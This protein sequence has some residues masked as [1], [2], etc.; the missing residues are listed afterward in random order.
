MVVFRYWT[1]KISDD[2]AR[3]LSEVMSTL[4]NSFI[5]RPQQTLGDLRLTSGSQRQSASLAMSEPALKDMVS[6]C[7]RE[8]VQQL[9]SNGALFGSTA[10][11]AASIVGS[12]IGP[13]LQ[14]GRP[15]PPNWNYISDSTAVEYPSD[16]LDTPTTCTDD[17]S[18]PMQTKN[19]MLGLVRPSSCT[20][21]LRK[22]WST[23]LDKELDQIKDNAGFFDLGGDSIT[24]MRLAGAAR[25][26]GLVMKVA[27][28]FK[29]P[30]FA[31]MAAKV[32]MAD[33][34]DSV[35]KNQIKRNSLVNISTA[36]ALLSSDPY[37]RYSL[38]KLRNVEAFLQERI[39]PKIGVFR[40]GIA[41]VF[42]VTNFQAL[43]VTGVLL[44]CKW[45]LNYF[46]LDGSGCV[47][48]QRLKQAAFRV[49]QAF[50]IFRTLFINH[51]YQFLQVVVRKLVPEFVVYETD[52]DLDDFTR[53]LQSRDK[54]SGPQ[55]GEAFVQ[56]IVLKQK[57][58]SRHRIILRMSH[59]QYDGVCLGKIFMGLQAAYQSESITPS[60]PFAN[61]VRDSAGGI[62]SQHYNYWRSFLKG[63]E[64]TE[65]LPK[66][67]PKYRNPTGETVVL[68]SAMSLLPPTSESITLATIIKAAWSVVLAR[69]TGR[70]NIIFG[71]VISGRNASVAGVEDIVG[72]CVNL[73]P[74]RVDFESRWAA[75]DL[76]HRIQEQQVAG[77]PY[78]SLGFR[79]IIK[80]CTD[81]PDW[82]HFSTIVQHQ[83]VDPGR[84]FRL[85]D[86]Q[87]TMGSLGTQENLADIV[88][89]S[90]PLKN[91]DIE[92]TL[93]YCSDS[94]LPEAF[95]ENAFEQLCSL[96]QSF[97]SSP[98]LP[99]SLKNDRNVGSACPSP[100]LYD[101]PKPKRLSILSTVNTIDKKLLQM[102]SDLLMQLWNEVLGIKPSTP[103]L[104]HIEDNFFALGGDLIA[105]AALASLIEHEAGLRIKVEELIEYPIMVEQLALLANR[106]AETQIEREE[107]VRTA[108]NPTLWSSSN[109]KGGVSDEGK[110]KLKLWRKK[111]DL[112]K[113]VVKKSG[114][115]FF[116][117]EK[118]EKV[119]A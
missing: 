19:A 75:L 85:G 119:A 59:A 57:S 108:T 66:D 28:V 92:I 90:T 84:Q 15:L 5:D 82:M 117:G 113:K 6:Q 71:N 44:E 34:I 83:N 14:S 36:K 76:L 86:N 77:M 103:K 73:I 61:Y 56:F 104:F 10:T 110:K 89:L 26:E 2:Q 39:C 41:D 37:E 17:E 99:I 107:L 64:M 96:V 63:S 3:E 106:Q 105:L 32:L 115:R 69:F 81:W 52:Q 1:D 35:L 87:Y 33:E 60:P 42:P 47:D 118:A 94:T 8:A 95:A 30:T 58:G 54:D 97:T 9:V 116:N 49:V 78:E 46:F 16:P 53:E 48:I 98:Q 45:M 67:S 91:G 80:H 100:N 50:D 27:D 18:D 24:A 29:N 62:S 74:V 22:L 114:R 109:G 20:E 102:L 43:A 79:D 21:K 4:L 68:R 65:I 38:L 88:L 101:A 25:E 7:V 51:G 23:F 55:L 70:N 11:Q 72:P 40:G 111:R 12:Q 31:D 13:M 93:S 112:A